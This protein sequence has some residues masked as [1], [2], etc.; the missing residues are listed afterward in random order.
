MLTEL[1]VSVMNQI[2]AVVLQQHTVIDIGD[3]SYDLRNPSLIRIR[4]DSPDVHCACAQMNEE[5][6]VIGMQTEARL[7]KSV[8]TSTSI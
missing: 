8:A 1:T 7:K 3:I 6:N 2:P 5:Q 4:R